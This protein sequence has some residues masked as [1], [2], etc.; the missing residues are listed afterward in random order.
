MIVSSGR[1]VCLGIV[2]CYTIAIPIWTYARPSFGCFFMA[3][4]YDVFLSYRRHG[5]WPE[6]VEKVFRPLFEHW[7]GE[8]H[9]RVRIFIDYE[10]E[11]GAAWPQRLGK[12]LSESRVLVPLFSRQYFSSPWCQLELSQMSARE[13]RCNFRTAENPGGLIVPAHIHDG[14]GFPARAQAIQAAKLQEY[15]NVRLA[16][17]SATEEHLSEE[18]RDWVPDIATAIRSAPPHDDEWTRLT[19][20]AF[21]EQFRL[22][23]SKQTAPPSLG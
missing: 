15:T 13:A 12:A 9:P 6:W 19:V 11:S 7:L 3:Y 18:I 4:E 17:G 22:G 2:R 8:E 14:D 23:D 21:V 5:E 1:P 20:E 10:I 16:K